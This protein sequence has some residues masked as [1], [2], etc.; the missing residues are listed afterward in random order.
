MAERDWLTEFSQKYRDFWAER[1]VASVAAGF[2]PGV[3]QA[4]GLADAVTSYNDPRASTAERTL[5]TAGIL[6]FGKLFSKASGPFRK[7]VAGPTATTHSQEAA[8]IA[9]SEGQKMGVLTPSAR[10]TR[11]QKEAIATKSGG[12]WLEPSFEPAKGVR[13]PAHEISDELFDSFHSTLAKG[14]VKDTT[15]DKVINH[16]VLFDAYPRLKGMKVKIADDLPKDVSGYYDPKNKAI[17]IGRDANPRTMLHEIQHAVADIEGFGPGFG[18]Y[19]KYKKEIFRVEFAKHKKA[20][21]DPLEAERLADATTQSVVGKMWDADYGERLA[22][23]AS[24]KWASKVEAPVYRVGKKQQGVALMDEV[25]NEA[26]PVSMNYVDELNLKYK[27]WQKGN[28]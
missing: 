12:T 22:E 3:G 10:L 4:L 17:I 9:M 18:K 13:L 26:N 8:K 16:K 15:L 25:G 28:K 2:V 11:Q 20:G 19:E 7:I 24:T 21:L 1:P 27:F 6:P 23:A 5:A 14:G